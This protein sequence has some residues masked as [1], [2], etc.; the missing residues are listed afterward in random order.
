MF[1]WFEETEVVCVTD[2]LLGQASESF[3]SNSV[4]R[5]SDLE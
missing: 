3:G 2:S 5:V 1:S 4:G